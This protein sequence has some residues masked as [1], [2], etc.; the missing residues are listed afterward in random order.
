M[1]PNF[2][3]ANVFQSQAAFVRALRP[4][5]LAAKVNVLSLSANAFC[6][7]RAYLLADFSKAASR[8]DPPSIT[9][10]TDEENAMSLASWI[11]GTKATA[12]QHRDGTVEY[13][14]TTYLPASRGE[15]LVQALTVAVERQNAL[16]AP[17]QNKLLEKRDNG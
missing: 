14:V 12:I 17:A 11:L 16:A 8:A 10:A 6:P 9:L 5:Q 15:R 7:L 1:S 2:E 4:F 13:T 3:S